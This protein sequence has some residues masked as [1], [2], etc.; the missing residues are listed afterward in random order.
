MGLGM[1]VQLLGVLQQQH[2]DCGTRSGR[3]SG[4]DGADCFK[5]YSVMLGFRVLAYCAECEQ[6]PVVPFDRSRST[7]PE[8]CNYGGSPLLL[9]RW[10]LKA[11]KPVVSALHVALSMT[12]VMIWHC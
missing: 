10:R 9:I 6:Q 2:W 12:T 5:A 3:V 8:L 1:P 7:G 4:I 11:Y